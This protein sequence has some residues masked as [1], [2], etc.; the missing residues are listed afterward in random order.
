MTQPSAT[1][2]APGPVPTSWRSA[3]VMSMVKNITDKARTSSQLGE[4]M[5]NYIT[6]NECSNIIKSS[7]KL[8]KKEKNFKW[9]KEIG[10]EYAQKIHRKGN[11]NGQ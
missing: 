9:P 10:E 7:C 1:V 3:G 8:L 11:T 5:Y 6:K 4:N 2:N